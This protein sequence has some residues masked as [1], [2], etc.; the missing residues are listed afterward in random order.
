M[1]AL[2]DEQKLW[3]KN[4][5][6][7]IIAKE[8]TVIKRSGEKIPYTTENGVFNDK[9][10]T[11]PSW[12]T[13][14]FWH[15][16]L[17]QMYVESKDEYFRELACKLEE[18]MDAVLYNPEAVHHDVGFLWLQASV[19]NWRIT[20]NDASKKRGLLAASYLTSRYNLGGGFITAWNGDD[21][22]NWSIIDT[23]MNL[24]LLYWASEVTGYDRY[25]KIARAHADKTMECVIRPDGSAIHIIEYDLSD[26]A[27]LATQGGQGYEVGSSWTRGQAWAIYGFALSWLHTRDA[28][29]LDAAK[30]LAHYFLA[31]SAPYDYVPPID[32]RQPAEPRYIDTTA[33]AI[34]AC[35]MIEIAKALAETNESNLY[36]YGAMRLLGALE[37][38]HAD[39]GDAS[40]AILHN[41]S[42]AYPPRG[43]H[44]DIIY[45]DYFFIE[46]FF[47][48][49]GQG[50]IVF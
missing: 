17:W 25:E 50:F 28:R 32:F 19:A 20:G 22:K 30:R 21:R 37:A 44:M 8:T 23:M 43:V 31:A 27:V 47:K 12:W 24:P 39:W 41:G 40:D 34:A 42:E 4:I 2:N 26:G 48:L 15:G 49:A 16:I 18:R 9:F 10:A 5:Y 38:G 33:G 29:Y 7:K 6:D 11:D 35:G 45:G 1:L 14:C 36:L 46:A 3:A 13:N